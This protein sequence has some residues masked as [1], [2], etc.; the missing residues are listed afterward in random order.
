V[1]SFTGAREIGAVGGFRAT[2]GTTGGGGGT[3]SA[4]M[5]C[6]DPFVAQT[7]PSETTGFG[8]GCKAT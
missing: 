1:V 6:A 4:W 2:G 5:I 7:L 8:G 3:F